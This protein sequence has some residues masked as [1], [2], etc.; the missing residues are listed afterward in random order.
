MLKCQLSDC[1]CCLSS[2]NGVFGLQDV[3][4]FICRQTA[5]Y[6]AF[7]QDEVPDVWVFTLHRGQVARC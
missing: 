3:A 6:V 1:L 5:I 4:D 7:F 2:G